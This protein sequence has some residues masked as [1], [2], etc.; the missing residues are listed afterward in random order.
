MK[1]IFILSKQD[2]ELSKQEVLAL[3]KKKKHVLY[4]NL[5]ITDTRFR[6]YKR[7]AYTKE[8]HRLLFITTKNQLEKDINNFKWKKIYKKNFCIRAH[9]FKNTENTERSLASL[10]WNNLSLPK[11]KLRNPSTEIIFNKINNRIIVSLKIE[12]L[13]EKFESRK[14]HLRPELH[15]SSLHPRLARAMVNLTGIKKGTL[16]DPFCGSGG[17]LIEAGMINLKPTGYDIDKIMLKRAEINLKHFKIKDCTLKLKDATKIK[18]KFNYIATDLPYSKNT[19]AKDLNILYKEFLKTL[20]QIL[21]K[22]AVIGFPD[23]IDYKKLIKQA[24]LKA[25]EEFTYYLH[26]SLT[27]KIVIIRP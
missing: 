17:I 16:L 11:A 21:K 9:N 26:K 20:K 18:T 6:N 7:L 1:T 3:T 25:E 27:K 19:R 2:I 10:I 22:K 4:D 13:K 23:F 14:P 5:L 24:K 8:I 12:E 15:P